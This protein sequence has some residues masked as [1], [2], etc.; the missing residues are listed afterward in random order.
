[1]S[2]KSFVPPTVPLAKKKV[3]V[4]MMLASC[5]AIA[6]SLEGVLYTGLVTAPSGYIG[7][8]SYFL[9]TELGL[10]ESLSVE[11]CDRATVAKGGILY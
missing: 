1:M 6:P 5:A 4:L 8:P 3:Q 10:P 11:F 9:S 2:S 7:D